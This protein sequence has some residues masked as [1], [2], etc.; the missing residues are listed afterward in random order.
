MREQ[1]GVQLE[2]TTFDERW[3][4]VDLENNE[5]RIA[6]TDVFCDRRRP[7]IT[8][9]GPDMTRRFEFKLL[10]GETDAALLAP[11]MVQHLLA[12]HG[13]DPRA[14]I[15]RKTVSRFHARVAQHWSFGRVTLA[16]DA[17]HLTPPFAGQGM[18]SGIRDAHNVAWKLSAVLRGLA[19]PKLL[20]SYEQERKDHIWQMVNLALRM[21]RVMSP[22]SWLNGVLTQAGFMALNLVPSAR[23]YV[24]QMKYKPPP[25]FH[26]GFLLPDGKGRHSIV[27]RMLQ[28]P[29]VRTAAGSS[30]LLDEVLGDRFTL[31][32][33]TASPAE[34]FGQLGQPVWDALAV[35]R[36]A[37]L[38]QDSAVPT[39]WASGDAVVEL[40][41]ALS[42]ALARYDRHALLLRPDHYV[43]AAIPLAAPEQTAKAMQALLDSTWPSN[44]AHQATR[45]AA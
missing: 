38:P 44:P 39:G 42:R 18:N 31:L 7:C 22:P 20:E 2:G 13:A 6:H 17:A 35:R 23:D 10:P 37:I 43:A 30:V 40:G 9:P 8:L 21:G 36:V 26:A 15:R 32:L 24:A 33:R 4:I 29:M 34:D 3:L 45:Q 1:Q 19:G 16:G 28:Q 14:T 11:D 27:G 25:R 41:D 12:S 5:N